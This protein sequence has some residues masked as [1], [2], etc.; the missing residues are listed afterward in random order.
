MAVHSTLSQLELPALLPGSQLYDPH[1]TEDPAEYPAEESRSVLPYLLEK[2]PEF[3]DLSDMRQQ[4]WEAPERNEYSTTV[5]R[6]A[7]ESVENRAAY[8]HKFMSTTAHE[9]DE[10]TSAFKVQS[11]DSTPPAILDMCMTP[12]ALLEIALKRNPGARALAFSLPVSCGGYKTSLAS[13]LNTKRVFLDLT[14]LAADMGVDQIPE[15]HEDTENFLP[16][17]LEEGRLFDLVICDGQVLRQHSRAPYGG[18]R[19]AR[20]VAITQLALG[21]QHLRPGGTMIILLHRLETWNTV[22]VIWKFHKISSVRLFKPKSSYTKRSTFYMVATNVE[23]QRLE[24][25]EAVKLWKRIWRMATFGS[26]EEYGKVLLDEESSVETLLED[27][28][29]ELVKLGKA[30]WKTEADSLAKVPFANKPE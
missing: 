13:N 26:D 12:G 23:S 15:G 11:V 1:L 24:A 20:R 21:L 14:M 19:G 25:I 2:S 7:D 22:N 29:P 28:G 18:S 5:L 27:F 16:Q 3:R 4:G 9:F 8:L 6:S 17:Q 30:I 10:A